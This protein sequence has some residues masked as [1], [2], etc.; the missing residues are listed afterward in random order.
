MR[1]GEIRWGN[2]PVP[3]GDRKKRPFLIVSDDAFNTN[4]RYLKVLV[5]HLTSVQ[6]PGGPFD[7]EVEV[8][9]GVARLPKR[10]LVKCAEIYTFFKAHL[11]EVIGTL[12]LAYVERVDRALA[13][14]LGISEKLGQAL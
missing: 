3:G 5:V 14:A 1:R 9:R 12:P 13:V 8:P 4:D 6:R 7:W 2:P 11:G 10:S